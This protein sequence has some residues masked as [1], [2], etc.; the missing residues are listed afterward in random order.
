MLLKNEDLKL[1]K[2]S[3]NCKIVKYTILDKYKKRE[4]NE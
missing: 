1:R 3:N 4:N 2:N